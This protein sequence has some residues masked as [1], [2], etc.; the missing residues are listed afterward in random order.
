MSQVNKTEQKT[1]QQKTAKLNELVA[2]FDSEEFILEKAMDVFKEAEAL[3]TDIETDLL[4]I[5]NDI[6][7]IKQKFDTEAN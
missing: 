2:W 5:K 3:A 7:V 6:H 4:S 1:I